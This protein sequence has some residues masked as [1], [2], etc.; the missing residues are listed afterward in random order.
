MTANRVAPVK[1]AVVTS[2]LPSGLY[3]ASLAAAAPPRESDPAQQLAAEDMGRLADADTAD[4]H[5]M[6]GH[7]A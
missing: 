5:S 4:R 1:L 2:Q 7:A 6:N 3:L